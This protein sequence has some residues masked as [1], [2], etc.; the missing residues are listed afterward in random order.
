MGAP[1]RETLIILDFG[2]QYTQ[3]IARKARELG[4]FSLIVPYSTRAEEV[5]HHNPLGIILSGGP[6][7]VY[8]KD[9]P[10]IDE[11]I[12]KLD[13]PILGI[14]YGLQL[15]S[16]VFGGK[17]SPALSREYGQ[18]EITVTSATRLLKGFNK[19]TIWMSHGDHVT[20]L[21]NGFKTTAKSNGTICVIEDNKRK[22]FGF[23]FHPEVSQ[24]KFGK[25]MLDNFLRICGFSKNWSPRE[26]ITGYVDQIRESVGSSNVICALSGGVDSSVAATLVNRA[27]G[28]QQFCIFVDNGLLRQDEYKDTLLMYKNLGLNIKPVNA[29]KRF[30]DKLKNISDPETKRKVIGKEFIAVFEEEASKIKNANFLVQ[31]TLYPDIIESVSV[32]GPSVTIKSHHNVGGLPKKMK[33]KLIEPLK[34][35]FKDEVRQIGSQLGLPTEIV[36]RQPFPGPGLAVRIIGEVNK[37]GVELLQRADAIVRSVIERTKSAKSLYQYFAVLLPIKSVGVMGDKRSYE[38]VVAIRAVQSADGMTANWAHI[39][40]KLMETLSSKII[41]EVKGVNRVVYDITSKPPGPIEWE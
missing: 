11:R 41:S 13:I 10:T 31:G 35:L 15:L 8:D 29:K 27:I 14:C 21:P 3:L 20:K 17:V 12:L 36:S 28:R 1:N 34:M 4:V 23:Q 26:L 22:I 37:E 38:Q 5:K 18:A 40:H 30:L 19:S 2:S 25:D 24:T 7:S 16:V 33:L 32:N 39:P 6:N 9:A